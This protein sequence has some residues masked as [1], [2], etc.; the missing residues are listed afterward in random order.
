M[1]LSTLSLANS[2]YNIYSEYYT[3]IDSI[4]KFF[5]DILSTNKDIFYNK[6]IAMPCDGIHSNF[7]EHFLSSYNIYRWHK[8]ICVEYSNNRELCKLFGN[9][10]TGRKHIFIDGKYHKTENL[11]GSGD[12]RTNEVKEIMLSS[13]YI[14]TNPP[15]S[16]TQSLILTCLESYK[17]SFFIVGSHLLVANPKLLNFYISGK[18]HFY[19]YHNKKFYVPNIDSYKTIGTSCWISNVN[20]SKFHKKLSCRKYKDILSDTGIKQ[21]YLSTYEADISNGIPKFDGKNCICVDKIDMIP[22]DYHDEIAVPLTISLY[23][24]SDFE[25]IGISDWDGTV[26]NKT[27][28]R[29]LILRRRE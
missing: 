10:G 16:L 1:I 28:F 12:F 9:I 26:C 13:D 5:G 19:D 23:D 14:I 3:Q 18:L 2:R 4:Q 7:T 24:I 15:F 11:Y 17:T 6:I 20:I 29:R 27:V 8:L 22:E 25:V 21:H